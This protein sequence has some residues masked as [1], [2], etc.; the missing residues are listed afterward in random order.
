M[1]RNAFILFG[2]LLSMHAPG[3]AWAQPVQLR[4][5]IYGGSHV[6]SRDAVSKRVAALTRGGDFECTGTF[7]DT[8]LF[9]TAAHCLE[10]K[11]PAGITTGL[12]VRKGGLADLSVSGFEIHPE[13]PANRTADVDAYDIAL[14]RFTGGLPKGAMIA[15]MVPAQFALQP[16]DPV[17]VAGYGNARASS[18]AW[19]NGI[20][21]KAELP[22]L[23]YF[24]GKTEMSL[25]QDGS[26]GICF[27]DSGGPAFVK[28]QGVLHLV[29]VADRVW[30]SNCGKAADYAKVTSH[31]DWINE[32][33]ARLR[34]AATP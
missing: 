21:R 26:T 16:G 18:K 17:I 14:V 13:Y 7:I 15:P 25:E 19:G 34:G 33:A 24:L 30:K 8:D 11:K 29:G 32:A 22:V 1:A 3:F 6:T 31:F 2:V 12:D 9:L 20:L 23:D 27:G 10:G 5:E 28:I 4:P